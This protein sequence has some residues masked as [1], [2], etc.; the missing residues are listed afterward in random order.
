M[1]VHRYCPG[2]GKQRDRL[3]GAVAWRFDWQA[4]ALKRNP[5][6]IAARQ[7]PAKAVADARHTKRKRAQRKRDA[8]EQERRGG[9]L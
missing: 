4:V 3:G 1:P 8:L 6:V 2:A 5:H 9:G 7:S